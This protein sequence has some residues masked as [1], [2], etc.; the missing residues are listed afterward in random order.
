MVQVKRFPPRKTQLQTNKKRKRLLAFSQQINTSD[1][2]KP[3][4]I[5]SFS[6]LLESFSQIE[7]ENS[8]NVEEGLNLLSCA[9]VEA[10]SGSSVILRISWSQHFSETSEAPANHAASRVSALLSFTIPWTLFRA[11]SFQQLC[12]ATQFERTTSGPT[13]TRSCLWTQSL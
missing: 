5:A 9:I 8:G 6:S 13:S 11:W 3:H 7:F 4:A 1:K 12:P 10:V 2:R